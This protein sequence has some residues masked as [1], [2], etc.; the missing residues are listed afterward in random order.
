M[1]NTEILE[2]VGYIITSGVLLFI[3]QRLKAKLQRRQS[4]V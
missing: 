2:I 3:A 1:K 4:K